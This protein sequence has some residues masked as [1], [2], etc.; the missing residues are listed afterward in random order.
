M[1]RFILLVLTSL[2]SVVTSADDHSN[3]QFGERL[4]ADELVSAVLARNPGIE[5]LRAAVLASKYRIGP[6][7]ALDDPVLT[8]GVAPAT[9]DDDARGRFDVSQTLPWPGKLAARSDIASA[10]S[11]AAG[12]DVESLKLL[13]RERGM[14]ALAEWFEL[15]RALA[16]NAKHQFIL[17]DLRAVARAQYAAGRVPQQDV[18][19]TDTQIV[20]L[21]DQALRLESARRDVRAEING[22]L[23]RAPAAPLPPPAELTVPFQIPDLEA[24]I[25]HAMAHHPEIQ[26]L[27]F[28]RQAEQARVRSEKLAFKPDFRVGASYLG[29]MDPP[30]KRPMLTLTLNVPIDRGKYRANLDA[31]MAEVMRADWAL[32]DKRAHLTADLTGIHAS[33]IQARD[34]FRLHR[35]RLLPIAKDTLEAALADYSGGKG[36]YQDVLNAERARLEAELGL[37][38]AR[39]DCL[40]RWAAVQR[41]AGLPFESDTR[42]EAE[43]LGRGM[44]PVSNV[45]QHQHFEEQAHE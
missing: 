25:S 38:R 35:D 1:S 5:A 21:Q 32:Q 29:I 23:N 33:L 13:L 34:S 44:L 28:E 37:A 3:L 15:E 36:S 45:A 41:A 18:L 12:E 42:I 16:I 43:R 30:D 11:R 31:A 24:L 6:A 19:A 20:R 22:L 14:R 8:V 7:G 2:V 4:D 10:Q 17:R 26:R 40:R 9:I 39:A 27:N